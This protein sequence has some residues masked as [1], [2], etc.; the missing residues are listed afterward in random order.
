MGALMYLT[1]DGQNGVGKVNNT[2]SDHVLYL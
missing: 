1:S 2:D